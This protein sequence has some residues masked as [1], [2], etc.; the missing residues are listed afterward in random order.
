MTC[1][2]PQRRSDL[3]F[4]EAS[5]RWPRPLSEAARQKD[6][7]ND[8]REDEQNRVSATYGIGQLM[9]AGGGRGRGW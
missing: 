5:T 8:S 7:S 4:G 9:Q 3:R 2:H 6:R 1:V